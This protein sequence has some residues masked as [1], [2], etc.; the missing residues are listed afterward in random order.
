LTLAYE[1]DRLES[2]GLA[3]YKEQVKWVSQESDLYGYD[4][5]SYD[6]DDFGKIVHRYIEVKATTQKTDADFYVSKNELETSKRLNNYW[7]YR[8]YDIEAEK[9]KFYRVL[10]DI[11][12]NF[13]LE[14]QT[15]R[16]QI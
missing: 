5:L 10:G 11:E 4:I 8:I 9:P 6:L 3:D 2:I 1:K 12:K 15:Y 7:V 14:P 16:V 13:N